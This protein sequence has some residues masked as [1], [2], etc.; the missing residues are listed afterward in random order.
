MRT[1]VQYKK[2][3]GL[4][5][6]LVAA[7]IIL[8]FLVAIITANNIY[9]KAGF[10]NTRKIQAGFLLEEGVE[11]LRV[12]RDKGWAA[13][14]SITPD[15]TYY[16]AYSAGTWDKTSTNTYIDSLFERSFV[17][18]CVTRD[19]S[20]KI[21]TSVTTCPG[22]DSNTKQVTVSVAWHDQTGTTTRSITTYF[23]I[24]Q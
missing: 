13:F 15:T 7:S 5:E 12:M 8:L 1:R 3:M 22:N 19:S 16:L 4:V 20:D 6:I 11:A 17:I 23:Q 21:N 10:G 14:S 18:S 24:P 2:G 9:I